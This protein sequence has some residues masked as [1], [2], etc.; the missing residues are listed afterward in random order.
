MVGSLFCDRVQIW[1]AHDDGE[2]VP[3]MW[4]GEYRARLGPLVLLNEERRLVARGGEEV[5]VVGGF[6][7]QGDPRTAG[8][9]GVFFASKIAREPRE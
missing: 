6:L 5:H 2:L 7:P 3:T 4:P 1:L 9:A 8:Y